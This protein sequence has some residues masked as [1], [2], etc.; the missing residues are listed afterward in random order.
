MSWA[1]DSLDADMINNAFLESFQLCC[2]F[3]FLWVTSHWYSVFRSSISFS[4]TPETTISEDSVIKIRPN[5]TFKYCFQESN[6]NKQNKMLFDK[7]IVSIS[8]SHS[9]I[10]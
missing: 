3:A 4:F 8:L 1:F 7:L 9:N 6:F 2:V 10:K 5:E